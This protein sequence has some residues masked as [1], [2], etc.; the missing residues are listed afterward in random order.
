M[1]MAYSPD[2]IEK[3]KARFG[4]AIE[5]VITERTD[6]PIFYVKKEKI[7]EVLGALRTEEGFEYNFLADLTAYDDNPPINDI[8]DYGLGVVKQGGGDHRFVIVYQLFSFQHKDRVRLKV[9]TKEDEAVPSA[10]PVWKAANWLEREIYDMYGVK[11]SDHP[12]LRRIMLDER[13]IG[14]PQRKEYPIKRY[15][16]FQ[17]SL[18]LESFGLEDK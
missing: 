8:P 6:V 2:K 11:F 12:N 1:T 5:E 7:V 13:W 15:Q 10:T 14:H 18:P 9:R 3:I 16:R 4:D 17:G